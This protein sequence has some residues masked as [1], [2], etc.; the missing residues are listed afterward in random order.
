MNTK[1]EDLLCS[2]DLSKFFLRACVNERSSVGQFLYDWQTLI[3]GGVALGAAVISGTFLWVQI[4]N[5][6]IEIEYKRRQR[7]KAALIPMPH[8][9]TDIQ[10]YIQECFECWKQEN[11]LKLPKPPLDALKVIMDAAPYIDD[12][13]FASFQQLIIHSQVFDS[14]LNKNKLFKPINIFDNMLIDLAYYDYL[15]TRL[16]K[17][18]RLDED[19]KS[20][21]YI[22]PK[23]SD[24]EYILKYS[25]DMRFEIEG[26]QILTRANQALRSRYP[27][28]KGLL[29][30]TDEDF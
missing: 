25:F 22:K 9:L 11:L 15:T 26:S 17:Y 23:Q 6:K 14:R 29:T 13:S 30:I 7:V 10:D 24:I 20:V 5:Q 21:S 2:F 27:G 18:A 12:G 28:S 16:Y 4:Q 19:V 8:A 3:G 1:F